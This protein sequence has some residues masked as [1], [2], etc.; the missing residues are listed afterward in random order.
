MVLPQ[1]FFVFFALKHCFFLF[2]YAL[3]DRCSKDQALGDPVLKSQW[4]YCFVPP[5]PL[6]HVAGALSSVTR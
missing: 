1:Y 2:Q 4:N 6:A 5:A 3:R